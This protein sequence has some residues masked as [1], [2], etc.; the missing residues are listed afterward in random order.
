MSELIAKYDD[1]TGG[2]KATAGSISANFTD[3]KF[4]VGAGGQSVFALAGVIDAETNIDVWV[5]GQ[6]IFEG[7]SSDWVRDIVNEEIEFNNTIPENSF[8]VVR[9]WT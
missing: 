1:V 3:E 9:I 2:F 8:V 5:N 6:K 4:T 7:A